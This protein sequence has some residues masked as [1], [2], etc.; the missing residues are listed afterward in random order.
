MTLSGNRRVDMLIVV[1]FML[2]TIMVVIDM[3][4]A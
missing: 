3:V 4:I 2:T 1:S